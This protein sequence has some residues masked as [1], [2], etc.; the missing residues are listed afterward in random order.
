M[1]FGSETGAKGECG[2]RDRQGAAVS[3]CVSE[4]RGGA[5]GAGDIWWWAESE[6]LK[7]ERF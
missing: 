4:D 5:V 1:G 6:A 2:L 7:L 3:S